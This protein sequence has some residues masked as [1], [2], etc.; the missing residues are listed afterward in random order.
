MRV[1]LKRKNKVLLKAELNLT[2]GRVRCFKCVQRK[3]KRSRS[4]ERN[5]SKRKKGVRRKSAREYKFTIE[6][7][8]AGARSP[9]V[10]ERVQ[11]RNIFYDYISVITSLFMWPAVS[12]FFLLAKIKF[13]PFKQLA[14]LYSRNS[15]IIGH[16][17]QKYHIKR[18]KRLFP[19][20][21]DT[22]ELHKI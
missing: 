5:P 20:C 15:Y 8:Q 9:F 1:D 10:S 18:N 22:M 17:K 4:A 7:E 11:I 13:V 12:Y 16:Y 6:N 2:K 14:P 3:G 21:F 19:F